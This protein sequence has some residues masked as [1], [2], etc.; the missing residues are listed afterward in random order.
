MHCRGM[1]NMVVD[2]EISERGVG[3]RSRSED[4]WSCPAR[5]GQPGLHGGRLAIDTD[6]VVFCPRSQSRQ[7][8]DIS[9]SVVESL[10]LRRIED[11]RP[12]SPVRI[13]PTATTCLCD[14]RRRDPWSLRRACPARD[15]FRSGRA[16]L[17]SV[18]PSRPR[19]QLASLLVPADLLLGLIP[20]TSIHLPSIESQR[21]QYWHEASH[22][23]GG[24]VAPALGRLAIGCVHLRRRSTSPTASDGARDLAASVWEHSHSSVLQ[25]ST[26]TALGGNNNH[27]RSLFAIGGLRL[28][29]RASGG[30]LRGSWIGG[31]I[32]A[33]Q[34]TVS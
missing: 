10:A 19:P 12:R 29:W 9:T 23:S 17:G 11:G 32:P 15:D 6:V 34:L 13:D 28:R 20:A 33:S 26:V 25:A 21:R 2:R 22:R 5:H 16:Q 24:G 7:N 14:I 30:R 31:S 18:S 8:V 1:G 27:S 3:R 4:L